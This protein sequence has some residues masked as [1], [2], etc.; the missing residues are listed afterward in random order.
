MGLAPGCFGSSV[1]VPKDLMVL[2]PPQISFAAAATTP[3]VYTTVF[4]AFGSSLTP[5]KKVRSWSHTQGIYGL[6]SLSEC[7]RMPQ[8]LQGDAAGS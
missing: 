6:T 1:I 2:K 3:T 5:G 8:N 4:T 7:S